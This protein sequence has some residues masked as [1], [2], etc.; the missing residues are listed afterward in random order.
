M[1][2][3]LAKRRNKAEKTGVVVASGGLKLQRIRYAIATFSI[4]YC[5]F[6]IDW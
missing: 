1:T 3:N 5:T 6:Q 2:S 4:V